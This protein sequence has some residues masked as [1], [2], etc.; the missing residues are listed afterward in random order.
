M[1]DKPIKFTSE[2][3]SQTRSNWGYIYI[4]VCLLYTENIKH[5]LLHKIMQDLD[6]VLD[7]FYATRS[8]YFNMLWP[9]ML[10]SIYQKF[11]TVKISCKWG[12]FGLLLLTNSAV[13]IE[14][15]Q[16]WSFRYLAS[17]YVKN[18]TCSLGLY[19]HFIQWKQCRACNK[20][21]CHML[22]LKFFK[23]AVSK[24][25]RQL[26]G[27]MQSC[28]KHSNRLCNLANETVKQK[29]KKKKFPVFIST[30]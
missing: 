18:I 29:L 3:S 8:I 26:E 21:F 19:L 22:A 9:Q 10:Y 24:I 17:W 5:N 27:L 4:Y 12:I 30:F 13:G 15:S 2:S 23:K 14:I 28:T 7:Q 11:N 16:M 25:H 20:C 6:Q 1:S